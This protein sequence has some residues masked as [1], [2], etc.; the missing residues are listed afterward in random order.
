MRADL[1]DVIEA[2]YRP[3][4]SDDVWLT[5]IMR[6]IRPA[7]AADLGVKG[8]FFDVSDPLHARAWCPPV[9]AVGC[10]EGWD[11]REWLARSSAG[12]VAMFDAMSSSNQIEKA[13]R[14]PRTGITASQAVGR[15]AWLRLPERGKSMV[16]MG[17]EDIVRVVCTDVTHKGCVLMGALG[18]VTSVP[19]RRTVQLCRLAVH[20]ATGLRLRRRLDAAPGHE[21]EAILHPDG[22]VAHAESAARPAAARSALRGFAK[23]VDRARGKMRRSDP[24][25]AITLWEGLAAGRWSLVDHFDSDGKRYLIAHKNDPE[26]ASPN[27]LSPVERQIAGYAA[28]GQGNKFIAYELGLSVST[29]STHLGSA[30]IKLGVRSRAQLARLFGGIVGPPQ[31]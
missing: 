4:P 29:V 13:Y 15:E 20:V 19:R 25:A 12:M 9:C 16:S 3:A 21:G 11:E 31:G 14:A 24:D 1:V 22:R 5:E 2:C 6:A 18:R 23:A 30:M 28:M 8:M 10:P 26:L 7:L 17:V 27:A